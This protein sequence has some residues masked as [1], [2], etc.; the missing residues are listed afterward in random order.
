MAQNLR[1]VLGSNAG[2]LDQ[3]SETYHGAD[4]VVNRQQLCATPACGVVCQVEGYA[5]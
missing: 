1:A 5:D 3:L 2:Q 4:G